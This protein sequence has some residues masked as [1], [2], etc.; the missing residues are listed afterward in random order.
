MMLLLALVA[1]TLSGCACPPR[2]A[3]VRL[4]LVRVQDVPSGM[5]ACP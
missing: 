1:L 2:E 5:E 3:C 4:E